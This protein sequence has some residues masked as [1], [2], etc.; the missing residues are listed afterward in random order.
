[1]FRVAIKSNGKHLTANGE[2]NLMGWWM[3]TGKWMN[4]ASQFCRLTCPECKIPHTTDGD[5]SW[6]AFVSLFSRF[7]STGRFHRLVSLCGCSMIVCKLHMVPQHFFP[8]PYR[9]AQ[10]V[11]YLQILLK[12]DEMPLTFR[13]WSMNIFPQ[14]VCNNEE[15][16]H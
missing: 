6:S 10:I 12:F 16:Q 7:T 2:R 9:H 11:D 3:N 15:N 5:V 8:L 4:S 14:S 13:C 1:M